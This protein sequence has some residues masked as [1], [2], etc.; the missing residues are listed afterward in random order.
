MAGKK[1]CLPYNKAAS[2]KKPKTVFFKSK[3][4][5]RHLFP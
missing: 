5:N 2:G 4:G 3:S 1:A